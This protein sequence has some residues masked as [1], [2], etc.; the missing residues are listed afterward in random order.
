MALRILLGTIIPLYAL[1]EGHEAI[2]EIVVACVDAVIITAFAASEFRAIV[3][4]IKPS[5]AVARWMGLGLA[6]WAL[7]YILGT[8]YFYLLVHGLHIQVIDLNQSFEQ[9]GYSKA[10]SLFFNCVM[11][12]FWEEIAFRGIILGAL[13]RVVRPMEALFITSCVFAIL[14]RDPLSVP[15]LGMLGFLAGYL[16]LRSGSLLP[17][18]VV[19]C[20]NNLCAVLYG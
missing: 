18:M 16:R 12:A 4:M 13:L 5:A 10:V 19:H 20:V 6:Y 17:G 15:Y 7:L 11:P 2:G 9:G 1:S 14:H 3:A 8:G